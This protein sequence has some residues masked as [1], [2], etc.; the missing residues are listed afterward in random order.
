MSMDRKSLA[1][2]IQPGAHTSAVLQALLVVFLWATSWVLIKIGLQDLPP[3]TFAGLR[4]FLAFLLM[5]VVTFSGRAGR[6]IR[7]YPPPLIGRLLALGVLLYAATQGAMFV[8]LVYLPAVTVNLLWSFS[9]VLVGLLGIAWLAEKPTW[10][11]WGGVLLAAG[12]AIIYFYPANLP[13]AEVLGI[14]VATLGILANAVS[15]IL[16]REVN[17]SRVYNPL[18]ITT[19]SMGAG[20]IALLITG[21]SVEGLPALRLQDWAIIAWLAVVNTA[22]AFTLWNHTLRTLSAMESS[23]INGTML[24]WI[25][26]LAVLFLGERIDGKQLAGLVIAGLGTLLVQVRRIALF[27]RGRG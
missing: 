26:V 25:P 19:L 3:L 10:L 18:G 12:G 14:G 6:E 2:I 7:A 9:S 4:Y 11:Q 23:I 21:V 20:A 17:R 16:G 24:I 5:A 13:Q 22:F 27:T 1:S 15:A 8:A